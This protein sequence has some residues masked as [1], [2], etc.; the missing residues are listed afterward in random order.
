MVRGLNIFR[1]YF[2][3]Y[4]DNYV[5]IGGTACDIIIEDAGL[6]TRVTKDIDMI[7]VVEALTSDFVAQ[8]WKFI[9]AGKYERKEKNEDGRKYYRFAKPE[10]PDFPQQVELFSR[11]PDLSLEQGAHLTPIPVDDDLSSLSAILLSDVYYQYMTE[12]SEL[13]DGLRHAKIQAL[14]C[15]KSKA[16]LEITERLAKGGMEGPKHLKKHK[17]DVFRL[18][19]LLAA[20][21]VFEVPA[22]IKAHLNAFAAAIASDL[23]DKA[24]FEN[25]GLGTTDPRKVYEQFL[26]SF[27]LTKKQ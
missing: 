16:F 7:L 18:L 22:E 15:L 19:V 2:E 8:F 21:D 6:T 25:M 24:I 26:T 9:A 11:N 10:N 27:R 4:P 14:I 20:T 13:K 3:A 23:P 1:K 17:A 5:I 12:Q